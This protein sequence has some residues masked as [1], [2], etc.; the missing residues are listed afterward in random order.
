[1]IE[2]QMASARFVVNAQVLHEAIDNEVI[3]IDLATGSYYS[4]RGSA[5]RVWQ[6]LDRSTGLT[7]AELV[8]ALVAHENRD[9]DIEAAVSRFVG[10]LFEERLVSRVETTDGFEMT[11]PIHDASGRSPF[12]PPVL[13]KYTDMQDLVLLDPVH[14]VDQTGWPR[15]PADAASDLANA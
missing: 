7:S 12:E 1:M 14:E 9:K 3:I 10:E 11:L 8:N 4:L 15:V 6:L 5:A 13:E 2:D